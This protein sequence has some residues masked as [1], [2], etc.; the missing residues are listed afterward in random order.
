VFRDL[1]RLS[2]RAAHEP[3]QPVAGTLLEH[4]VA[5]VGVPRAALL[6]AEHAGGTGTPGAR[7][8]ANAPSVVAARGVADSEL[9][10]LAAHADW[11][12]AYIR[13]ADSK[14][15]WTRYVLMPLAPSADATPKERSASAWSAVL[16]F[17][18]DDEPGGTRQADT[19]G[20]LLD[21]VQDGMRAVL[22]QAMIAER[23]RERD[24][25]SQAQ[26][27]VQLARE[28]EAARDDR[29][30]WEQVFDAISDPLCIIS[31]DYHLIRAN[32]AYVR[33]FGEDV[34][35][36]E[37]HVCFSGQS[38]TGLPCAGCPLPTTVRS[39]QPAFVRQERL[40]P[41][42]AG[43]TP[44]RRIYERWTYPIKEPSGEVTRVVELVKDVTDEVRMREAASRSDALREADRLKAQL[45]GTVSHE[46]RSP[47]TI[48]K[49]FAATLLRHERR[50]P[51][52][53]RHEFLVGINET[54]DRLGVIIERLLEMSQLETG[55]LRLDR[56]P[57]DLV[58][59][60]AMAVESARAAAEKEAQPLRIDWRVAHP[61]GEEMPTVYGDAR[62]LREVVDNLLENARKYTPAGGA[63]DVVL[64]PY[65]EE[66]HEVTA[67]A[68][69][70]RAIEV[71]DTTVQSRP[72]GRFVELCVYDTGV[73]IPPEQLDLVF[74]RF[75]RVDMSL[76]REATGMGLGL[77]LCKR[78]VELHDGAIWAESRPGEGSA[79]HVLLPVAA[80]VS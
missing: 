80:E 13:V 57:V 11:N 48:I 35:Y 29:D 65:T 40:V 68:N 55:S 19:A 54:T 5:L 56:H 26:A 43:S 75:H 59:L 60:V 12:A 67:L 51:R 77:T 69:S 64:R 1:A 14:V 66:R 71:P 52:D 3:I 63:I 21:M 8:S 73:G 22:V 9:R 18:W 46:L 16:Y 4:T 25:M 6:L 76:M 32:A 70:A 53:E 49:G 2:V 44:D 74:D 62:R 15:T 36:R 28:T 58:P 20:P 39:A 34:V 42:A 31:S 7:P 27:Y 50:L 33:L 47:L 78:I 38:T 61:P 17:G 37:P 41:I 10:A 45:L 24:T 30:D 72:V 23:L 79:F